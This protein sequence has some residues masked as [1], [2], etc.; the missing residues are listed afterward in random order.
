LLKK[1]CLEEHIKRF[2]N[3]CNLCD[4]KTLQNIDLQKHM[5]IHKSGKPFA[6]N[7]C[8]YKTVQSTD[9]EIHMRAHTEKTPFQC[10]L[11]EFK[12]A[13]IN[14]KVIYTGLTHTLKKVN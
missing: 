1:Y 10:S 13:K 3:A 7:L 9:L 12:A 8:K 5:R 6:C 11:C 2:H 4:F 14:G